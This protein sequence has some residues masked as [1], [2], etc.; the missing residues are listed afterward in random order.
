MIGIGLA[1]AFAAAPLWVPNE[2]AG[3]AAREPSRPE[4]FSQNVEI[5]CGRQTLIVR[6]FGACEGAGAAV[7]VLLL[8][9]R[10]LRG[11]DA[12]RMRTDLSRPGAA[13]RM[14]AQCHPRGAILFAFNIG[15]R[16]FPDRRPPGEMRYHR[17]SAEIGRGRIERYRGL[18]PIS[19]EQYWFR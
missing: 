7:P 8:N 12:D 17:G 6:G 10:T 18:Q 4:G 15:E 5:R 3:P 19:E 2:S 14:M 1:L 16:V 13:Y 9:G 11:G